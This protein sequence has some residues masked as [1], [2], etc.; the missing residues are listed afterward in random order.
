MQLHPS[1]A[2]SSVI[3]SVG[4]SGYVM[5]M[6]ATTGLWSTGDMFSGVMNPTSPSGIPMG[7]TGLGSCHDNGTCLELSLASLMLQHTKTFCAI[8]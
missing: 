1:H 2:S 4:C 5:G 6:H 8:S 7:E 3:Q